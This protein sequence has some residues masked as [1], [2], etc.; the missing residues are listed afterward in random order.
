MPMQLLK[1]G[2][3]RHFPT[4]SAQALRSNTLIKSCK[5]KPVNARSFD[6]RIDCCRLF[7]INV[8][9]VYMGVV[10]QHQQTKSRDR[11]VEGCWRFRRRC[12]K[13]L[14]GEAL[15]L[16]TIALIIGTFFAAVSVAHRIRPAG[17]RIYLQRCC[18]PCCSFTYWY[19]FVPYTR[20]AGCG[21]LSRRCI[22]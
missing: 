13:Q 9:L 6:Y 12:V 7:I 11:F 14:V 8:A 16:A 19:C 22:A 17:W 4:P 3:Q 20:Q 18:S 2:Y 5:A 15:V 21:N 1:A 10:V